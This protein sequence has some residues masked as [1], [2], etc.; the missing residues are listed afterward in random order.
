MSTTRSGFKSWKNINLK[1][2]IPK[3]KL[4]VGYDNMVSQIPLRSYII[5]SAQNN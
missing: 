1:L 3:K 2:N 5:R 4:I